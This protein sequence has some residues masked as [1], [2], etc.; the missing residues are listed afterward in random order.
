[1]KMVWIFMNICD[2]VVHRFRMVVSW[3]IK[4]SVNLMSNLSVMSWS[5]LM[6]L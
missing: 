4:M 2:S 3:S 5:E 1:M 6:W